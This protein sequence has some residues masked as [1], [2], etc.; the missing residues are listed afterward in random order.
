VTKNKLGLDRVGANKAV[1]QATLAV[2]GERYKSLTDV[3][4]SYWEVVALHKR[5]D[6][7]IELI[8]HS[9][10]SVT[11]AEKLKQ[12]KEASELDVV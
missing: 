8:A 12:A 11:N 1:D 6:V 9:E 7:L 3:R 5:V 10:Q 4:Q 2:V